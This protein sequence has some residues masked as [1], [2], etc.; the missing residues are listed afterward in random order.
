MSVWV[1]EHYYISLSFQ[2]Q[3][4]YYKYETRTKK[5]VL[6]IYR[7]HARK[8]QPYLTLEVLKNN[9]TTSQHER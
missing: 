7:K 9:I 5:A 4:F 2:Q 6:Q 8:T 1:T 3:N